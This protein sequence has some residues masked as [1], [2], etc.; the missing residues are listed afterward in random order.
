MNEILVIGSINT[1]LVLRA[2]RFPSPGETIQAGEISTYPGGKGANQ[3]VAA[4]R[5]GA[6]VGM[7]GRVGTDRHGDELIENLRDNGVDTSLV[8]R[9]EA[10]TGT[11]IV[12]VDAQGQNSIVVS[13]GANAKVVPEDVE[14]TSLINLEA[15][16]FQLEVPLETVTHGCELARKHGAMVL[17]NPAPAR[18]LPDEMYANIDCL[19]PNETELSLLSGKAVKDVGSAKEAAQVMLDKGVPAVV[20][21]LGAKGSLVVTKD[22]ATHIPPFE[23]KVLDTTGA[24]DAFI[25][26]FAAALLQGKTPEEAARYGNACGALATTKQGAQS[27]LPTREEVERLLA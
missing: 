23:V 14:I 5:Q 16:L 11:A 22:G 6:R 9:D 18:A 19:L 7:I 24:G 26:G 1:D 13:P 27:S 3:A 15:V 25:G 21:T 8:K 2:E 20:V 10:P 4:A 17:L 12:V